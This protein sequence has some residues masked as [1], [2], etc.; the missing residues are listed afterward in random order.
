MSTPEGVTED[1]SDVLKT[2]LLVMGQ[3]SL[4]ED[5]VDAILGVSTPERVTEDMSDVLKTLLLVVRQ[6]RLEE[7]VV[8][9][10]LGV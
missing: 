7:V 2:L 4:E 8:D 9:T 6:A 5:G 1:M 10:I 3:A